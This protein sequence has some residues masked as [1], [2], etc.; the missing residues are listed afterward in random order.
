V[1]TNTPLAQKGRQKTECLERAQGCLPT[2]IQTTC[3]VLSYP[4][5]FH[6]TPGQRMI[7]Q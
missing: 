5:G 6:L 1:P 2:K 3:D 7:W 4:T